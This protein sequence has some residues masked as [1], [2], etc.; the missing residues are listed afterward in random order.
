M[1]PNLS[2]SGIS[3]ATVDILADYYQTVQRRLA[4]LILHPGTRPLA[5]ESARQA[6]AAQLAN[7]VDDELKKL[8]F[9]TA[10]WIN[11]PKTFQQ[12]VSDGVQRAESQA[13]AAGVRPPA[14][15]PAK[16]AD[17][18]HGSFG[19][20]D[21][22]AVAVFARDAAADLGKAQTSMGSTAKNLLRKTAQLKLGEGE[23]NKIL[24]GG[25]I[26][27]AP[28]ATIR[29]L[30]EALRAVHGDL[31]VLQTRGGP[32]EYD[33]AA[34]A[35]LVVRTKTRE[36]TTYA[37]HERLQQV[38][39][40]LVSIVGRVSRTFCTAFLGQVFSLSGKDSK[41]PPISGLPGQGIR[42]PF[43]PNCSKSTRPF[44]AALASPT[45]LKD[46]EP[47]PDTL[48]LMGQSATAAQ[49]LFKSVGMGT[50]AGKRYKDTSPAM[51]GPTA[52]VAAKPAKQLPPRQLTAQEKLAAAES[53]LAAAE[54]KVSS[55]VAEKDALYD[56]SIQ[57]ER[58]LRE[59]RYSKEKRKASVVRAE[60]KQVEARQA[61]LRKNE[62]AVYSDRNKHRDSILQLRGQVALETMQAILPASGLH[63]AGADKPD[64][65]HPVVAAHLQEVA[66]LPPELLKAASAK[67]VNVWIDFRTAS[68]A[69][70]AAEAAQQPRGWTAGKTW[71]DV[72]GFYSHH[73]KRAMAGNGVKADGTQIFN[74]SGSASTVIHEFG[75]ALGD[76]FG[77]NNDQQLIDLHT[78]LHPK[79]DPYLQQGGPGAAAGRQ[80]LLAEGLAVYLGKSPAEAATTY[81]PEFAEYLKSIV[82]RKRP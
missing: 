30:R 37:R 73:N 21:K 68:V 12:A 42:P 56:K 66:K 17:P 44:I 50:D 27:G 36:A 81:S 9:E 54:S 8:K 28:A 57:L 48:A 14:K 75:H 34:Y 24:A 55:H 1:T 79:L 20:I 32:R 10:A 45:Q 43:H 69:L 19:L 82:E 25:V 11:S 3:Q 62:F 59:G 23:I 46:G 26:E 5:S 6:R 47:T 2:T 52:P 4:G 13:E 39:I 35:R 41:Y 53:A 18:L 58:E 72:G 70:S 29:E 65:L 38:G 78:Q 40:D 22:G 16:T 67:G 31:I 61:G 77:H 71:D 15:A 49:A 33:V 74:Y 63:V 51:Y 80:E 7:Q 76:V 60:I 64:S